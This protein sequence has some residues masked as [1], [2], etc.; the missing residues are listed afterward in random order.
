MHAGYFLFSDNAC[1]LC[2][3]NHVSSLYG[4]SQKLAREAHVKGC[5]PMASARVK[6]RIFGGDITSSSEMSEDFEVVSSSKL[7]VTLRGVAGLCVLKVGVAL[8]GFLCVGGVNRTG[9]AVVTATSNYREK[10]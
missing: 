1:T 10:Y 7:G 3:L 5:M 6:R 8:R 2:L 9:S 4:D